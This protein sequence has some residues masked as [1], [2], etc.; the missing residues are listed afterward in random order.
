MIDPENSEAS[1]LKVKRIRNEN[2]WN[3][4]I[5]KYLR[6]VKEEHKSKR[7]KII[8]KRTTGIIFR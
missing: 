6:T 3:M 1:V 2:E 8:P 4:N 5:R 7:G